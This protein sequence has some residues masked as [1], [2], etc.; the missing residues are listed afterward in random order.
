[1]ASAVDPNAEDRATNA[2]DL[3][4]PEDPPLNESW[5]AFFDSFTNYIK[6]DCADLKAATDR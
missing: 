1:M 3:S 6:G 2:A 4:F 5:R